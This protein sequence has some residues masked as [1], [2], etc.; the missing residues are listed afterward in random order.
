MEVHAHSHTDRKK[1]THYFWEFLM[2][3]LAVFC[4]FLAENQR[5]HY[6]ENQRARDYALSLYRDIKADTIIFNETINSLELCIHNI[7]SLITLLDRPDDLQNHIQDF[8]R[9]NAYAFIFPMN[10]PN[11]ATLQQLM[12]SG[13]LRYLKNSMLADSIKSYSIAV[14]LFNIFAQTSGDFNIEFR[15]ILPEV[16][17]VNKVIEFA[18][19]DASILNGLIKK[20]GTANF[21]SNNKKLTADAGTLKRYAG[22]CALKKFYFQNTIAKYEYVK[23]TT[24]FI[25]R[26]IEKQYIIK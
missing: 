26:T 17:D 11:E 22:W 9:Y 21:F 8:Y 10:K 13:S 23:G 18:T 3:F 12:N 7:D 1:W 20:I 24:G 25:L 15:K 6:V 2:L 5:E 4:G 16:L 14:Q 19:Q